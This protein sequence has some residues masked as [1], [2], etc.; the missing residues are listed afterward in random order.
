[1]WAPVVTARGELELT[2]SDCKALGSEEKLR[3]SV[4]FSLEKRRLWE[5]GKHLIAV[6]QYL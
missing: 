1:M 3:E 5:A 6:A 2:E 4:L